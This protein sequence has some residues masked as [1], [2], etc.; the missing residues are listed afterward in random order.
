MIRHNSEQLKFE[1]V[2]EGY[3]AEL[4]YQ[5]QGSILVFDHTHVPAE[6]RGKGI[7]KQLVEFGIAYARENGYKIKPKC[8]YVIG[9]F[10]KQ[11]AALEDVVAH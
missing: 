3:E 10:E 7:A 2:L 1:A 6:L 9:Y 8:T 5:K 4:T 11:S